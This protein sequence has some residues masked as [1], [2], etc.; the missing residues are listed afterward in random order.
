MASRVTALTGGRVIDPVSGFDGD[1]DVVVADGVIVA[2][3]AGAAAR[4]PEAVVRDCAGMLVTPGLIDLHTHVFPG[5]GDFCVHPDRAGVDVGVPVVVDAGTSGVA[6]F[7]LARRVIEGTDVRTRVLAWLDPCQLYLATK[8]FIAHKLRIADD[9]RNLDLASTAKAIEA[10][11]DVVIGL[12]VRAT[13]V[14]DPTHSPFLEGAKSVADGV[15]IMIHLGAYPYTPSLS[16]L[17]AIAA[18]RDGDTVTHAF[19]GHSG[20]P[21]EG[22]TAVDP[23]FAEAVARGVRLDVGHSGSDFR[24]EAARQL[25]ALGYQPST[26]STD[27]NLFNE[28]RPVVS[29]PETMSKLLALDVPL[30][31]V[32][33][34]VTIEAARSICREGELGSLGVGRAAEVSVLRLEPGPVPLSDGFETMTAADRLV[35]AGCLRAGEWCDADPALHPAALAVA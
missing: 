24:F 4:Y 32:I 6:T 22:G 30:A 15:P 21:V 18:L 5:L 1:A 11:A 31:D 2:V 8:D 9:P 20:F 29:L 23:R 35:P 34:M 33:A 25:L 26:I 28:R 16:N 13:T 27:L 12:K 14:D 10:N 7:G 3:G 19:R 17:D